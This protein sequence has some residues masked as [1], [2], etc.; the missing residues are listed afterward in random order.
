MVGVAAHHEAEQQPYADFR[1]LN[2][3]GPDSPQHRFHRLLLGQAFCAV[4]GGGKPQLGVHIALP[5]QP[6][7]QIKGAPLQR[8]GVLQNAQRNV[9]AL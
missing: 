1:V 9:E 3:C 4:A 2:P 8:F 6:A 7:D 5:G